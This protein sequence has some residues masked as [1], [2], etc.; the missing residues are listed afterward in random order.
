MGVTYNNKYKDY[1][2]CKKC[3]KKRHSQCCGFLDP[4]EY[5]KIENFI[6]YSCITSK[7]IMM[8]DELKPKGGT[9][10]VVPT[11]LLLQWVDQLK[12]HTDGRL[13][14]YMYMGIKELCK[15]PASFPL[16]HPYALCDFDIV[17]T[18]FEILKEELC[19][20]TSKYNQVQNPGRHN[21][22][23]KYDVYP[24]V[25]ACIYWCRVVLD[26]AQEVEGNLTSNVV[27]MA[28]R[29]KGMHKW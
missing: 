25:L 16:T 27:Q 5:C 15:T 18:S 21:R 26:E 17:L 6:C 22:I 19:R 8:P 23:R 24:S 1:I 13:T 12:I 28:F 9:L 29:L 10:I 2:L 14:V 11:T 7:L 4:S 20:T 3:N